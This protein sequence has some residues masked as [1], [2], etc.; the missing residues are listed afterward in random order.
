MRE[1][2]E[3]SIESLLRWVEGHEYKGFEPSDGNLS[4]LHVLTLNQPV[5]ERILQQVI[6]KSP[7]DIR[8]LLGVPPH[9]STKGTGYMA[10]GYVLMHRQTG[11]S[12]YRERAESCFEWLIDHRSPQY[13]QYCWGDSFPFSSR[14][15][16]RA[17]FEPTI[18]WSS[19]IGQA[20]LAGYEVLGHPGYMQVV[21][22]ICDWIRELPRNETESGLCL[23]YTALGESAIHNSNMLGGALLAKFGALTE[24]REILA[25]AR[26]AMEYSCSRQADDGSWPYG[27]QTMHSWIDN[28]HTGYNLDSLRAYIAAT[29]DRT[30][31]TVLGR[32]LDYYRKNFFQPDG[33][34]KYY[35][36][37]TY[38]I[39]IQCAS[40]SIETLSL[41]ADVNPEL[42]PLAERVAAWTIRRMQAP[43]GHFCYRDLGWRVVATPMFHWGQATMFKALACFLDRC[44]SVRNLPGQRTS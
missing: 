37:R 41:F 14:G 6:W 29:G 23:G 3:Q 12:R 2:I 39:D 18:V 9:R 34:P 20:F 5:L 43:D 27:E 35:N 26:A 44:S 30:F 19:L 28:F 1:K 17:A 33:R 7:F 32:G 13:S 10:W 8:R 42:L 40:Q 22:S 4:P 16:R 11:E 36:N 25:L 38:P 31:D 24:D 15:G 21:S